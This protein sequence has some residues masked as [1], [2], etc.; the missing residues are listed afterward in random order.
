MKALRR[1]MIL[2]VIAVLV[3][4]YAKLRGN[5]PEFR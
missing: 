2:A 3:G 5:G 1:G 4:A